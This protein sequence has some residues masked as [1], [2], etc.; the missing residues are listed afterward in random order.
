MDPEE[1]LQKNE[2]GALITLSKSK[3]L[4]FKIIFSDIIFIIFEL[5]KNRAGCTK[6]VT[7]NTNTTNQ[8]SDSLTPFVNKSIKRRVIYG[9]TITE[10]L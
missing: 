7:K 1:F 8:T 10:T 5:K 9:V 6:Q 2:K 4:I 3:H